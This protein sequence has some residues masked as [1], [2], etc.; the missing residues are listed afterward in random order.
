MFKKRPNQYRDQDIQKDIKSLFQ[1]PQHRIYQ[2][3]GPSRCGI[4]SPYHRKQIEVLFEEK[5]PH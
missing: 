1:D 4:N 2:Y 5:Y 3:G